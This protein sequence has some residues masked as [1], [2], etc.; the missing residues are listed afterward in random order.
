MGKELSK[1]RG[2][3]DQRW[4]HISLIMCPKAVSVCLR[5]KQEYSGVESGDTKVSE[6]HAN[7]KEGTGWPYACELNR[8][9]F[10]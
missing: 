10:V 4:E 2:Q 3:Q 7:S 6:T 8:E 5:P 1:Q 9:K